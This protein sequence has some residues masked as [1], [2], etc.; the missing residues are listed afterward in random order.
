MK[1]II[2]LFSLLLI[3]T[4]F[5]FANTDSYRID[6]NQIESLFAAAE[7]VSFSDLSLSDGLRSMDMASPTQV[8]SEPTPVVAFIIAWFIGPLGI[9]RLYLGTATLTFI[10]YLCTGGGFGIVACGDWVVLLIGMLND[11][12]SKYVD[13]PAFIMW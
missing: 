8:K 1:K 4:A 10:G 6:D 12:I 11:D 7:E 9:H 5:S 3:F 13:N 2:T